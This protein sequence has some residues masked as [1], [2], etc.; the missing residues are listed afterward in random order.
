MVM[1]PDHPLLRITTW[2]FIG[3]FFGTNIASLA[4]L[5]IILFFPLLFLYFSLFRPIPEPEAG[6]GA[7]KRKIKSLILSSRRKK[8]LPVIFF[9]AL[10]TVSWFFERGETVSELFVPKARP[11]VAENGV[12]M[13]PL[14]DPTMDLMDG[15]LY[16]FTYSHEN[17]EIGILIIKKP[18]DTLS[19]SLDACEICPPVGYGQRTDHVVCIYCRTPISID[20]LGQ[21]GGCN[22]IPLSAE[23]DGKF[24]T[25]TTG[26]IL[27][28]WGFVL[29]GD[30]KEPVRIDKK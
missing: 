16:R 28:K 5:I 17:D 11:V 14:S 30:S 23:I 25:I 21:P 26:E 12:I 1:V 8:A 18:D 24:I 10:I 4:S 22:P 13:I 6:K 20:T 7:E 2:N 29:S 19:V 27:D 9:I 15:S 3:I